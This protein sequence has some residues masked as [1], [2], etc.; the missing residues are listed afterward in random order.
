MRDPASGG[1]R[2]FYHAEIHSASETPVLRLLGLGRGVD[3]SFT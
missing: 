1:Q 3:V 2:Q